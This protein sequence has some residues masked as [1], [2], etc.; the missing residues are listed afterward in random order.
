MKKIKTIGIVLVLFL[1]VGLTIFMILRNRESFTGSRI[2]NSDFYAL[3]ITRMNG[4]D[5]HTLELLAGDIVRIQFE[6]EKGSIEMKIQ[7]P[8]NAVLYSGNGKDVSDFTV[9]IPETGSYTVTVIAQHAKGIVH[10]Q[11]KNDMQ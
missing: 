10:I 4:P 3:D 2:K 11:R 9:N 6:T 8:S 7:T 5:T 1:T